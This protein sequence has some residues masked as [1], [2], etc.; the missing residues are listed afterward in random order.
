MNGPNAPRGVAASTRIHYA[1]D[2]CSD[3]DARLDRADGRR[4]RSDG[5][6]PSTEEVIRAVVTRSGGGFA[7]V[8]Y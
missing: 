8:R 2:C 6:S 4:L 7:N 1:L 3:D 5:L